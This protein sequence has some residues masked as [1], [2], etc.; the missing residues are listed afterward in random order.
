MFSPKW[1]A[2]LKN[3]FRGL[4]VTFKGTILRNLSPIVWGP[5]NGLVGTPP[6]LLRISMISL[7]PKESLKLHFLKFQIG[8]F[9]TH[10]PQ[11][12]RQT[13]NRK[14]SP[15]GHFAVNL[16][17][18][19]PIWNSEKGHC[20]DRCAVCRIVKTIDS[21]IWSVAWLV[22]RSVNFEQIS[23]GHLIGCFCGFRSY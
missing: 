22:A 5:K 9:L 20:S 16:L 21:K 1:I 19:Q 11:N 6:L 13:N 17:K 23:T 18:K 8:C 2:Q 14:G 15:S 7:T 12:D 4:W 3:R 10:W